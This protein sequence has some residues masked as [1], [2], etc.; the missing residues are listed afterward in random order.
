M[1]ILLELIF[2]GIEVCIEEVIEYIGDKI[3]TAKM[4]Q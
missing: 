4:K 1:E 2:D 3:R